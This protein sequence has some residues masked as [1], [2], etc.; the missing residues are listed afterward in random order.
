MNTQSEYDVT[1][2]GTTQYALIQHLTRIENALV[3]FIGEFKEWEEFITTEVLKTKGD[4]YKYSK[5]T[6]F[7]RLEE[8]EYSLSGVITYMN[9]RLYNNPKGTTNKKS[10]NSYEL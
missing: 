2:I 4:V 8:V 10:Y 5:K 1:S 7:K 9:N 6:P 3:L